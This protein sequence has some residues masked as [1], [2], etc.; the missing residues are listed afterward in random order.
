MKILRKMKSTHVWE[1]DMTDKPVYDQADKPTGKPNK[2]D[3]ITP[4]QK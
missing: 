4:Q 3:S 1:S 2:H